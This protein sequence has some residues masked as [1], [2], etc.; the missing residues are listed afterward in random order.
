MKSFASDVVALL[1]TLQTPSVLSR[2]ICS[3]QEVE[4]G[5]V[6][7]VMAVTVVPSNP[8][9]IYLYPTLLETHSVHS[10]VYCF[11]LKQYKH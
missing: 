6:R 9:P 1:I 3:V 8:H 5:R 10:N 7:D 11:V 4:T 2:S